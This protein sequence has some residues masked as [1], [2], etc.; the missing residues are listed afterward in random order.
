MTGEI[1]I[2]KNVSESIC[3]YSTK[4]TSLHL[5]INYLKKEIKR[6]ILLNHECNDA[7][8]EFML[9]RL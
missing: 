6:T 9:K 4:I 5:H 8:L 1:N 2:I 3:D 7:E